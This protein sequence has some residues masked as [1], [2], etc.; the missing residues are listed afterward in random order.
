[1]KKKNEINKVRHIIENNAI[2]VDDLVIFLEISVE[3]LM[4]RFEDRMYEHRE[5]FIPD[6]YL[7]S[8]ED[9]AEEVEEDLPEED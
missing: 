3:D 6:G 2:D 9:Y 5:K 8:E 4:E 1:M 7:V